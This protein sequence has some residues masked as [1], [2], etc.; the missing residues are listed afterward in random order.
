MK[1][2]KRILLSAL[3]ICVAM[4]AHAQSECLLKEG[5]DLNG[6]FKKLAG[7]TGVPTENTEDNVVEKIVFVANSAE[8]SATEVSSSYSAAKAYASYDASTKTISVY[9]SA[10]D[11]KLGKAQYL[12][13]NFLKLA[14]VD[15]TA[16][17][18]TGCNRYDNMFNNCHALT[19]LFLGQNFD[20]SAELSTT[21]MF[22]GAVTTSSALTLTCSHQGRARLTELGVLPSVTITWKYIDPTF[23]TLKSGIDFNVTIKKATDPSKNW[24]KDTEEPTATRI[25]FVPNSDVTSDYVVSDAGSAVKAYAKL[26]GTEL[27]IY[28]SADTLY[29]PENF[30][31]AFCYFSHVTAIDGWDVV[32]AKNMTDMSYMFKVMSQ[33]E[34]Q[35]SDVAQIN[36]SNVKNMRGLFGYSGIKTFKPTADSEFKTDKVTSMQEMFYYCRGLEEVDLS[37]LNAENVES[38]ESMFYLDSSLTKANL[39]GTFNTCKVTSMERMFDNCTKLTEV[40]FNPEYSLENVTTMKAMFRFCSSLNNIVGLLDMNMNKVEDMWCM[41]YDCRSLETFKASGNTSSVKTMQEMF[42]YCS[43]LHTFDISDGD[44]CFDNVETME[45]M[46]KNCTNLLEI[47]IKDS[48]NTPKLKNMRAMFMGCYNDSYKYYGFTFNLSAFNTSKVTNMS[49]MFSGCRR[50]VVKMKDCDLSSLV[51]AHDMFKGCENL[52]TIEFGKTRT[53]NLTNTSGM[54]QG[55]KL[56]GSYGTFDISNLDTEHV[57]D[58]SYMFNDFNPYDI[59]ELKFGP[60]FVTRNVTNM[61]HMFAGFNNIT[62]LDLSG[63]NTGKVTNMSYMFENASGFPGC[64]L[65]TSS[66]FDMSNVTDKENMMKIK[67]NILTVTCTEATKQAMLQSENV[68]A[69]LLSWTTINPL[70]CTLP[71]VADFNTSLADVA[72]GADKIKS[73]DLRAVWDIEEGTQLPTAT[74]VKAFATYD[75]ETGKL[76]ITTPAS[77]YKVPADFSSAFKGYTAMTT[78]TGLNKLNTSETTKLDNMFEGCS[79]FAPAAED[80]AKLD[81]SNVTSFKSMFLN[82]TSLTNAPALPATTLAANCYQGMFSGCTSLV[83]APALPATALNVE[84]YKS[85]FSGCTSLITAPA[86]P[87]TDL[88]AN[89]YEAMFIGCTSLT[90]APAL[91]S[92][93]MFNDCYRDMFNGCTSLV[94]APALP[95]MILGDRCYQSMFKGC[96]SMTTAPALPATEVKW[97]CYDSMFSGCTSLTQAPELPAKK[98]LGHCYE[99]MFNGCTSLTEL[100]AAFETYAAEGCLTNWLAGTAENTTG[101]FHGSDALRG[102][103]DYNLPSNWTTPGFDL[104]LNDGEAYT[105]ANDVIWN[106]VTYNRS[107]VTSKWNSWYLPF[108]ITTNELAENNLEAAYI[109]GVRQYEKD[110]EG[111]VITQI[112]IIRITNAN[113]RPATPYL[114][115]PT[116]DVNNVVLE[117]PVTLKAADVKANIH[118]ETATAAYDFIGTY[119]QV[120]PA[121]GENF[122]IM[123]SDGGLHPTASYVPAIDWYMKITDKD[124][125]FDDLGQSAKSRIIRINEIG[126]ED[127]ATGIKTIYDKPID[128]GKMA[129]G[130]IY[131]LGGKKYNTPVKGINIIN[132]KTVIIK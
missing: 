1:H 56:L 74:D 73:V 99:N 76:T 70:I 13:Q 55:C 57:T 71:S 85:M 94:N 25:S 101:V 80:I 118:T 39:G 17:N 111:N 116:Q 65:I 67:G 88:R 38:M 115:R 110:D 132:G 50:F 119:E 18:T 36:T 68:S 11:F 128:G 117:R 29:L 47:K 20:L 103:S 3:F 21:N 30:S 31:Y 121:A 95:A 79:S 63:F 87:A 28:T 86:L 92:Q 81:I 96:T 66:M 120:S 42:C 2:L 112:D 69:D 40:I 89:C 59:G 7:A 26:E 78:V 52:R 43:A 60:Y 108:A 14:Y 12:F 104:I 98:L 33:Y 10:A 15:I 107:F 27:K 58:M 126:S 90:N 54:F 130:A 5:S 32:D 123:A 16:L 44:F 64:Q 102:K 23:T 24:T 122:Y 53:V 35:A 127:H 100:T 93:K 37:L 19:E 46:F 125:P 131:D 75:S 82:C 9:T 109:A 34:I 84:C 129:A 91:P 8:T 41:F 83:N 4:I 114:V 124:V 61:S 22:T 49:E 97:R 6:A 105:A 48:Y 62:K 106:T 77:E 113:L 51:D 45:S 72:G